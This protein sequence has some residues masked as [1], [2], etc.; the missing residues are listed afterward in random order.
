[1][2]REKIRYLREERRLDE[3]ET[4]RNSWR[5]CGENSDWQFLPLPSHP[6]GQPVRG[7]R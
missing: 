3:N 6:P 5:N 7:A 2:R 4:R 1:V